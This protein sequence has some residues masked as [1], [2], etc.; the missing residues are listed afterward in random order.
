MTNEQLFALGKP[1]FY[2]VQTDESTFQDLSLTLAQLNKARVIRK[3]RGKKSR[4]VQDF[5]HEV[6]AALQFPDYLAKTGMPLTSASPT[7]IG[8]RQMPICSW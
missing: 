6:A 3:I 2:L 4:T 5:F 8:S 7:W 1:C